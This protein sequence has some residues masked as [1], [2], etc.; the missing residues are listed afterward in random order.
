MVGGLVG[1]LVGV[2]GG[3][4]G[5]GLVGVELN[6][7]YRRPPG[8]RYPIGSG[9]RY[10]RYRNRIRP[11]FRSYGLSSTSTRSSSTILM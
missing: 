6:A 10:V 8:H 3:A 9:R 4:G 2:E 1:G 11:R 5:G 7:G